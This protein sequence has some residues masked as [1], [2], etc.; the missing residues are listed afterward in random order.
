[1]EVGERDLADGHR[2]RRAGDV[3]RADLERSPFQQRL[4][5]ISIDDRQLGHVDVGVELELER[6]ARR[7]L[8]RRLRLD[9]DRAA[10]DGEADLVLQVGLKRQQLQRAQVDAQVGGHRRQRGGSADL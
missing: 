7:L 6:R 2:H 9:R 4:L 5:P 8:D 10:G 3:Q 1:M